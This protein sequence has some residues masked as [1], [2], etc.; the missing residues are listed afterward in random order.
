MVGRSR[1]DKIVDIFVYLIMLGVL[2]I[3]LYPVIYQVSLSLSSAK[4]V[5]RREVWLWP[6]GL[7]FENYALILKHE[8]LPGSFLNSVFYTTA[9]TSYSMIL[10]IFGAFA[11][12][13]KKYFGR[14]AIMMMI[15]FTMIF[16]GGLIPT[17]LL[18]KSLGMYG[19]RL[20]MIIPLA[21]SPFY[22]ITMRTSMLQ[23]PDSI[24]ESAKIDGANDIVIM[25][26]IIIPMSIPVIIAIAL[27]YAV[28]VWND[29]FT[30]LIYLNEK[31]H[32]P[33]QLIARELLVTFDDQ[34]FH[35]AKSAVMDSSRTGSVRNI[36]PG[37]FRAAVVV[38]II[39]PLMIVYPF[40]QKYF[41]KGVM[42][43]AIKG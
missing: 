10:T 9:S 25:F 27:F 4:A 12:S 19:S 20:A 31:K 18:V 33:M 14:D 16:S 42:I 13:R 34:T 26:K 1:E 40:L 21:V 15:A 23:I 11:L 7:N 6:V 38:V 43:G 28:A 3:T 30:A 39:L 17:F 5:N 41:I 8:Y 32:Y 37:G 2:I 36:T 35:R 24:E 29:F 22:L